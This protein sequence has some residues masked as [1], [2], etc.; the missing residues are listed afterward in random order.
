MPI[1]SQRQERYSSLSANVENLILEGSAA[2]DGYGNALDNAMTGNNGNNSLY[3][4]GGNDLIDGG[5]GTDTAVFSGS[6]SQYHMSSLSDGRV[7]VSDLRPGAPD[8]TDTVTNT[9]LFLFSDG[10]VSLANIFLLG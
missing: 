4:A 7:V 8:G 9:E 1:T 6:R 5:A 3:G 2:I 10:T